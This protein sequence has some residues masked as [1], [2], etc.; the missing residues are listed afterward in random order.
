M[1]LWGGRFESKTDAVLESFNASI[2]Y[3]K[4]MWKA[5]IE[6]SK[7]YAVALSKIGLLTKNELDGMIKGKNICN[8]LF[9][10]FLSLV[11][12]FFVNCIFVDIKAMHSVQVVLMFPPPCIVKFF[13]Q[14]WSNL[15]HTRTIYNKI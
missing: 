8:K 1:K 6:G 5:D 7:M 10:H 12:C 3:D 4:R 11:W 2:S 14:G 9:W 13:D 15:L